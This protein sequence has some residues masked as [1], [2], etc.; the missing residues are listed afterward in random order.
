MLL[1]EPYYLY[2]RRMNDRPLFAI[3]ESF[4]D[5]NC[6][7]KREKYVDRYHSDKNSEILANLGSKLGHLIDILDKECVFSNVS[8]QTT[9]ASHVENAEPIKKDPY[10]LNHQRSKLNED[11]IQYKLRNGI[12]EPR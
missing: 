12:I 10:R 1:N 8:S 6:R 9:M 7:V 4:K 2:F 3:Q 5:K 11:E